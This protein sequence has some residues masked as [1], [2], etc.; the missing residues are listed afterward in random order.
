MFPKFL[1]KI[2]LWFLHSLGLW[3]KKA[4]ILFVGLDNAGKT[5][6]LH[7]LKYNKIACHEPTKHPTSEQVQ[8]SNTTFTVFDIG[9]HAAARR[10][11]KNY[12]IDIDCVVFIIDAS[13]LY[14]I[15]EVKNELSSFLANDNTQNIPIL[16][17]GN[18]IDNQPSF[19]KNQLEQIL[20]INPN[21]NLIKIF[22][23]SLVL[24][25]NIKES[26]DWLETKL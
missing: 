22:M 12:I 11:W 7:I 3:N 16:I 26:F 15:D 23:C 14:R 1:K 5:T 10:L 21:N 4:K 13:D 18:K 9:G 24:R 2:S 17:L 19:N 6:L 8:I 25:V 20:S